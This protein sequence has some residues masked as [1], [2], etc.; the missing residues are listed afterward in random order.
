MS[1]Y[2]LTTILALSNDQKVLHKNYTL[3]ETTLSKS[4]HSA[5]LEMDAIPKVQFPM[6][7]F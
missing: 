5:A 3:F 2:A 4:K 1:Q 7:H 6:W